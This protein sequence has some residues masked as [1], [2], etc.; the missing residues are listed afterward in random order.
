MGVEKYQADGKSWWRVDAWVI[1]HEGRR[2]RFRRRRIPTREQALAVATK[3]Q[4]ESFEGNFLQR[5]QVPRHTVAELWDAYAPAAQRDHAAFDT[6]AGRARHLLRHLGSYQAQ[7]LSLREVDAYR[8]AR[9]QEKTRRG[10]APAPATLDREVE[11][12]KRLLA[13]A[14][15]SRL[16]LEHPLR[17][18][19][20]LRRP[21]VRRTVVDEEGFQRLFAAAE[22]ALR[23]VLLVAFDTG[24]R[25]AEILKL[26][27][28]QVDLSAGHIRLEAEDTKTNQARLIVL[29]ERVKHALRALPRGLGR[30]SV[31]ANPATGAAWVD[32]R[33]AFQRA[34]EATKLEGLW[35]HDLRRSFVTRA[36]KHRIPESVVMRM[37]GHRTRAVFDRYNVVDDEDL[38]AAVRALENPGHV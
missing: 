26:R 9:L 34:L 29:T 36:R 21:N 7:R 30:A 14:V 6:D 37:S 2:V 31:F 23:P 17:D 15:R 4:A 35:F 1:D 32:L 25:K 18:V 28:D 16:L 22:E 38:R 11:L 10:A 3:V 8:G 33:K 12:L 20:L 5:K 27:W 19:P 24:M 13:Y